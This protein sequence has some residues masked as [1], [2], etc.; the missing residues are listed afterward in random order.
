MR[1]F[2]KCKFSELKFAN[3][4]GFLP[5]NSVFSIYEQIIHSRLQNCKFSFVSNK[6][7]STYSLFI[8][9]NILIFSYCKIAN[10]VLC[11][12]SQYS[13]FINK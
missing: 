9:Y 7:V 13:V 1:I 6:S 4:Y 2:Y 11:A 3:R 10:L 5:N 12:K 8:N